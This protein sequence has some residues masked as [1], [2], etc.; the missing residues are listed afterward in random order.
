MNA[1]TLHHQVV[2]YTLPGETKLRTHEWATVRRKNRA[3]KTTRRR[4]VDAGSCTLRTA[5]GVARHYASR[6]KI[7]ETAGAVLHLGEFERSDAGRDALLGK[8]RT[9]M[10]RWSPSSVTVNEYGNDAT[11]RHTVA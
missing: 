7:N 6:G 1:A 8:M 9:L 4:V 2:T 11:D 10:Y 3:G 5:R